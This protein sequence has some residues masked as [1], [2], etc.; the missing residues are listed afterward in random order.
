MPSFAFGSDAKADQGMGKLQGGRK[1][2]AKE[3]YLEEVVCERWPNCCMVPNV[4]VCRST[5]G[6]RVGSIFF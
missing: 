4:V 6:F 3:P 1:Q 2:L 5:Y